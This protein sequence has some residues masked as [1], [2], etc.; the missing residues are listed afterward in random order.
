L[1]AC[2]FQ[3]PAQQ[4]EHLG[5]LGAFFRGGRGETEGEPNSD[6]G[7]GGETTKPAGKRYVPLFAA[8]RAI[9]RK[10]QR[11]ARYGYS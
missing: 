3:Q 10:W 8:L 11:I 9:A 4:T 7:T 5:V 1:S 2:L 6:P